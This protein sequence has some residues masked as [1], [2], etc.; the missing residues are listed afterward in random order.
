MLHILAIDWMVGEGLITEGGGKFVIKMAVDITGNQSE[1]T[2]HN[3]VPV[4]K[5]ATYTVL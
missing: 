5:V 1:T 2:K 3:M 4:F